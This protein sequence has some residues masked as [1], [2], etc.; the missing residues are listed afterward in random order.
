MGS[1][2]DATVTLTLSE[3]QS[4][5]DDRDARFEQML[6][7]VVSELK[8]AKSLTVGTGEASKLLDV[9]ENTIRK[10]Q[11]EGKMPK[12]IGKGCHAKYER[13]AIERMAKAYTT[14]RH[15]AA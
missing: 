5:L 4:M 8:P 11:A 14:G 15:R 7:D 1:S 9:T 12:N 3:L 10:W 6:R 2:L 13:K